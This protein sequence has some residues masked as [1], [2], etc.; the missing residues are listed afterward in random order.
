LVPTNVGVVDVRNRARRFSMHVGADVSEGFPVAEAQTKTKTNIFAYGFEEGNRVS[1]GASLKGRV[2][3][4][5]VAG[6][7]KEWMTWCDDIGRKLTDTTISVDEVLAHFIRPQVVEARPPLVPLGLE[8][9]WELFQSTTEEVCI[10]Q[11]GS[12]WP[13]VDVAL[14]LTAHSTVGPISF[15]VSTPIGNDAYEL[16]IASGAMQF[17]ACGHEVYVRTRRSSRPLSEFLGQC[18]LT[19]HFEKDATVIPPGILLQ[20]DRDLP[21]YAP[22]NMEVLDWSG[23]DLRKESQGPYRDADS[24]QARVIEHL[25][26]IGNWDLLIDDDGAGEIADVV[27]MRLREDVLHVRLVHCKFSSEASP[28]ARIADLYEVCG[29]AQKSVRW[30]R[31]LGLMFGHLIRREK[32]RK[33][34]YGRTGIILGDGNKLYALEDESR[35]VRT[36]F[37]IVIAQP[38]LAKRSISAP[39]LE[40]LASTEVYLYETAQATLE[41]Y[42]SP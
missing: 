41:V 33:N 7:I 28:G 18:G 19:V 26:T 6:S 36:E 11:H 42:C 34:R 24:I 2:W 35:Y 15:K 20:S 1:V 8:W 22:A 32:N 27:A 31:G 17:R 23:V 30:K 21:P 29:Q 9:P 38:G 37:S 14:E 25:Q 39:S 3:S 12:T 40:L 10:D 13:L 16:D 5:R 4:Y